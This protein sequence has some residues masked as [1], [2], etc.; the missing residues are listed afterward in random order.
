MDETM[1]TGKNDELKEVEVAIIFEPVDNTGIELIKDNF[2][3]S[4]I[5]ESNS[6]TGPVLVTIIILL[7][8]I[9]K[10]LEFYATHRD[11]YKNAEIKIGKHEISMKGYTIEQIRKLSESGEIEKMIWKIKDNEQ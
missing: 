11:S 2:D 10:A 1:I 5:W 9:S 7:E 8:L 3:H 6:F 4:T